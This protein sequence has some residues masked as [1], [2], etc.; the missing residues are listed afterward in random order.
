M[1]DT[2]LVPKGVNLFTQEKLAAFITR[3]LAE[4]FQ[5]RTTVG[6]AL[7]TSQLGRHAK[8]TPNYELARLLMF[9]SVKLLSHR[10]HGI[11]FPEEQLGRSHYY[12]REIL[13]QLTN[14]FW[15]ER[16][17]IHTRIR[18]ED[19]H[20]NTI[21]SDL[22]V[23]NALTSFVPVIYNLA[24]QT[25]P[26]WYGYFRTIMKPD[27]SMNGFVSVEEGV[28]SYDFWRDMTGLSEHTTADQNHLNKMADLMGLRGTLPKWEKRGRE[29]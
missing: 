19:G 29:E 20:V 24:A 17:G 13:P 21:G 12:A 3:L 15:S 9:G 14:G 25:L 2:E 4:N 27:I 18:L 26:D 7:S 10:V 23:R 16:V 22:A 11:A 6:E 8:N 5:N 28:W 1:L